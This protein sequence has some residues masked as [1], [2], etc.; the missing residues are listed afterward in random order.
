MDF[1]FAFCT[2]RKIYCREERPLSP[3]NQWELFLFWTVMALWFLSLC[4]LHSSQQR[5]SLKIGMCFLHNYQ[6]PEILVQM[7]DVSCWIDDSKWKE[8]Q[9]KPEWPHCG[10][11]PKCKVLQTTAEEYNQGILSWQ[12]GKREDTQAAH[13]RHIKIKACSFQMQF[14]GASAYHAFLHPQGS[15]ELPA[16][17]AHNRTSHRAQVKGRKKQG[18]YQSTHSYCLVG[19]QHQPCPARPTRKAGDFPA[20]LH[21]HN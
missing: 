2:K 21:T 14:P 10:W 4:L 13:L 6:L 8:T 20:T 7:T 17:T 3:L 1:L 12:P 9:R 16:V 11:S 19:Y 18:W 5:K 15:Y